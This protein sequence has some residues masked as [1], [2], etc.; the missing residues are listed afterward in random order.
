MKTILKANELERGKKIRFLTKR[1]KKEKKE[2]MCFMEEIVIILST[3][4]SL[5]E[6]GPRHDKATTANQQQKSGS[7]E[8]ARG[9]AS[10]SNSFFQTATVGISTPPPTHMNMNETG[11]GEG[12][13]GQ[14]YVQSLGK[15]RGGGRTEL[16][17]PK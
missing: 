8:E 14:G 6:Q 13:K 4:S 12:E 3:I 2:P 10:N 11:T 5:G 17:S 9:R 15:G 16:C 7:F 1:E